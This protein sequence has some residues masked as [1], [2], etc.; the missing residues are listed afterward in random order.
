M[1]RETK[2]LLISIYRDYLCDAQTKQEINAALTKNANSRCSTVGDETNI[3]NLIGIQYQI[4]GLDRKE[5]NTD[6]VIVEKKSLISKI[7]DK[8]KKLFKRQEVEED[9]II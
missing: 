5:K 6:L 3:I 8:I 4:Q 7:F 9:N 1:S 2:A